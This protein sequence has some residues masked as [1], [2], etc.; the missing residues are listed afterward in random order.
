MYRGL[1][2]KQPSP[3]SQRS[4]AYDSRGK[5]SGTP[6]QPH[7]L[8]K[9][10]IACQ[11]PPLPSQLQIDNANTFP[12]PHKHPFPNTRI[13]HSTKKLASATMSED[14]DTVT[15][16]GSKT[17]GGGAARETVVRGKSALN[18]AARSGAVIGT[19][20][21]FG[22]G[23]S[24]RPPLSSCPPPPHP[25]PLPPSLP[26]SRGSTINISS[27]HRPRNPASKANTSPKSTAATTSSSPPP[28]ARKSAPPSP[29]NANR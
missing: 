5:I 25:S 16:I 1:D 6:P 12:P 29:T 24:V 20:K 26:H 23:N 7:Q 4:L 3:S 2:H 28:S 10:S 14:W 9:N 11:Q 13:P 21:K 8:P 15:K 18:A 19:E 22:A 17:R 27:P